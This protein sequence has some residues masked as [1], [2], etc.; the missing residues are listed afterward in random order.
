MD[1]G[2]AAK[3]PVFPKVTRVEVG[4]GF[5]FNDLHNVFPSLEVLKFTQATGTAILV[6]EDLCKLPSLQLIDSD[7]DWLDCQKLPVGCEVILYTYN[8]SDEVSNP[9][10]QM[11]N[12]SHHLA[13]VT[14]DEDTFNLAIFRDCVNLKQSNLVWNGMNDLQVDGLAELHLSVAVFMGLSWV[15]ADDLRKV[16]GSKVRERMQHMLSHTVV[17]AIMLGWRARY[18]QLDTYCQLEGFLLQH[19]G[20][21]TIPQCKLIGTNC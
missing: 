11:T 14:P 13:F 5:K 2:K 21:T 16:Y 19:D 7:S 12:L 20:N 18:F 1:L 9:S 15:F 10:Q 8:L 6:L 3:C 4:R 17:D